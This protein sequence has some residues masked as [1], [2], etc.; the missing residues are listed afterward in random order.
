MSTYMLANIHFSRSYCKDRAIRLKSFNGS[1]WHTISLEKE[2]CDCLEFLSTQ[3]CPHLSALGI[4]LL[5]PF[6]PKTH[7]TF[8]QALSGLVKSL[9][10][11]RVEDAVYWLHYLDTFKERQHRFRV[12]RRLL[13]G[14]AEDGHSVD[15]MES[16][17]AAFPKMT[18]PDT[19]ALTRSFRLTSGKPPPICGRSL[20]MPAAGPRSS[21]SMNLTPNRTRLHSVLFGT[22]F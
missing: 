16:V 15:V 21:S 10:I 11:R 1:E 4:H 6:T 5:R 18:K 2:T 17:L 8:S 19:S 13:I 12:A 22:R 9:R 20:T 7:P 14:A 3:Q